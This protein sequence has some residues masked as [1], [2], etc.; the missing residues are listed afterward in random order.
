MVSRN[1]FLRSASPFY[2][3]A[4]QGPA[5]TYSG[6]LIALLRIAS[7]NP[8][9]LISIPRIKDAVFSQFWLRMGK[10]VP[11]FCHELS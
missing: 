2:A 6:C 4:S 1:C 3:N 11:P 10:T 5:L 7:S 9:D 8:R